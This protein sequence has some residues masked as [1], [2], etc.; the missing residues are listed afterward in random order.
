MV[1]STVLR[2]RRIHLRPL[3][4][5]DASDRYVAWLNDPEVNRFL[6]IRFHD[7]TLADVKE[8]LR[9]L[10]ADESC[11][12][13]AIVLN[14]GARHIGN[15]KLG[16]IN[17]RHGFG[18]VSLFIGEKDCWGKGLAT[19]AIELVTEY[20]FKARGLRRVEAG[21]YSSNQGSA[22]AFLKAGWRQEAI[23]VAK[24]RDGESIVDGIRLACVAP[25]R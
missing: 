15:I 6:E 13:F 19:E 9:K 18:E 1:A 3:C 7:H 23:L 10:E 20:A 24:W 2:G 11:A 25:L 16:P 8:F 21:A 4:A 12:G 17:E 14:E 5:S 22:K